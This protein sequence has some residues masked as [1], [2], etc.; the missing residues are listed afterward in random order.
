MR[1]PTISKFL[2]G[3]GN[4]C[5]DWGYHPTSAP[6]WDEEELLLTLNHLESTL[7]NIT[8]IPKMLLLRDAYC[9]SVMWQTMSRGDN[10]VDWRLDNIRLPTGGKDT[11]PSLHLSLFFL[12][13]LFFFLRGRSLR[14]NLD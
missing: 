4:R 9:L 10:A 7:P 14:T 8:G 6:P 1:S 11:P 13:F 5:K 3:Y 2:K 12:F